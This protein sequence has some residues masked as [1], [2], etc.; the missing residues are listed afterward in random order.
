MDVYSVTPES[1]SEHQEFH[2]GLSDRLRETAAAAEHAGWAGILVPHNLHEI[3]PWMVAT[4]L[5]AVTTR[6]IPLIAVQPASIPPHAAA[7]CAAAY[8]MLYGR[9]LHFNLVAGA[10]DDEM[11]RIGDELTHDQRYDRMR[12]YAKVLRGLLHGDTVTLAGDYYAYRRFRLEPRPEVLSQCKIFVAGSSP[13][14]LSVAMDVAD[15]IVTHPAPF[16][17]WRE[18][19]LNVVRESGFGGELGIRIGVISRPDSDSAWRLAEDRFPQSWQG[20]QETLL[21][22]RSQ[23]SWARGLAQLAVADEK[24][25]DEKVAD[26]EAAAAPGRDPYW[27][28]AFTSGR[29]SAPYLVGGYDEVGAALAEYVRAGVCHVLLTGAPEEDYEHIG[30]GLAASRA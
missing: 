20:R 17:S 3:D 6:L 13:A 18:E 27:L 10:R 30:R 26:E 24:I 22:T 28:G 8:A 25:A 4:Y 1:V 21:K 23:N 5:G 14:S 9:P 11:R 15:V 16:G 7:S 29:A 19:F 12:E 2:A